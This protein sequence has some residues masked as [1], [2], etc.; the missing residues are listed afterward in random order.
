MVYMGNNYLEKI[1]VNDKTII[2]RKPSSLDDYLKL[3]N[4]Q[5]DI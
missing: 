3:M 4:V 5:I 2:I 1:S